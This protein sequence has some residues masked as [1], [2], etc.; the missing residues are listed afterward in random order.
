MFLT[1]EDVDDIARLVG[2]CKKN[3]PLVVDLGAGTGTTALTVLLANPRAKVVTVDINQ[4][5][6]DWADL[7]IRGFGVLTSNWF[8]VLSEADKVAEQ[9]LLGQVDILLHDADHSEQAVRMDLTSWFQI[10]ETG[11]YIWVHDYYRKDLNSEEYPG[12]K[13]VCDELRK[14]RLVRKLKTNGIGFAARVL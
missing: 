3:Q 4:E 7:N 13:I 6:L 5:N 12:V 9:F 8:P 14:N 2:L 11:A 1:K 10:L